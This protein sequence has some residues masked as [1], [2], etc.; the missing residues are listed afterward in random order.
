MEFDVTA[1]IMPRMTYD[2]PLQPIPFKPEWTHLSDLTLAD[3]DF[4]VPGR[5]DLLLGIDVFTRIIRQGRRTGVPGSPSAFETMFGWV[6]AGE[7]NICVSN[8]SVVRRYLSLE[9]SLQSKNRFDELS[10]VMEEYF[11]QEHAE[12][13]PTSDLDK[14]ASQTFYLPMHAVRKE[15]STTTKV[16]AVF[17]ASAASSS[18]VSLNDLLMVGPTVHSSLT[19]V[20]IRFRLHRVAL[21]TDVSRMYRAVLLDDKDLHRFVWRRNSTEPLKDDEGNLRCRC[22]IL[23]CQHGR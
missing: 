15:S 16:R 8:L 23:C 14:P 9:R 21:T 22:I 3:P 11:E 2:L 20:L 4:G 13:V 1:V 17:D 19:D 18:G 6:L 10:S 7:T 12:L 5:I